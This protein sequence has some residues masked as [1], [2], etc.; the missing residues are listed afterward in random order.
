MP[1]NNIYPPGHQVPPVVG[2]YCYYDSR[3][4][5]TQSKYYCTLISNDNSETIQ[6]SVNFS[7]SKNLTEFIPFITNQGKIIS[8]DHVNEVN[9]EFYPNNLK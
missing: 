8:I 5:N 6:R 3:I 9:S 2:E 4:K 7:M 1:T